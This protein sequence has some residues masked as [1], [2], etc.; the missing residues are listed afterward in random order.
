VG[1]PLLISPRKKKRL[2][3]GNQMERP[4]SRS[5]QFLWAREL[6]SEG[7]EH[8]SNLEV[9]P[10]GIAVARCWRASGDFLTDKKKREGLTPPLLPNLP[11]TTAPR[12]EPNAFPLAPTAPTAKTTLQMQPAAEMQPPVGSPAAPQSDPPQPPPPSDPSSP[13]APAPEAADPPA[14]APAPAPS[15]ASVQLQPK[16]VTWSEK[17]TSE[18]PTHVPAAAAA[19]S[20]Q[21][22]SRG[23]AASSSKGNKPADPLGST[24]Y[25]REKFWVLTMF[26]RRRGGGDEG[27]AVEV[28][29]VDG[30]DHQDGREPQPRHVAT[31]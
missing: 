12:L 31:L 7:P 16:T 23:P 19:E 29:K 22:V 18:S 26:L 5:G 9:E 8:W 24:L 28:G 25:L 20:S 1:P 27:H 13:P 14:P 4:I 6:I 15:L 30:G 21:Y 3:C 11:T 17:L 2:P 10:N